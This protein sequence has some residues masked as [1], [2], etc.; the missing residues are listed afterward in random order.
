[1]KKDSEKIEEKTNIDE[2][3]ITKLPGIVKDELKKVQTKSS[4][5]EKTTEEYQPYLYLYSAMNKPSVEGLV[6]SFCSEDEIADLP[7]TITSWQ[8]ARSDLQRI[9]N[10]EAGIA[11]N[12]QTYD[13]G[14]NQKL[15]DLQNDALFRNT[16]SNNPIEF[17]MVDID[18]LIATQRHVYLDYV[19]EIE[20]TI[21][22]NPSTDDLIDICLPI[23][24]TPPEPKV[25]NIG[26]GSWLFSSPS[27]D[28]RYLGGYLKERLTEDD[29]RYTHV[30]GFPIKAI[31][32]FVGYG[33]SP[34]NV[35]HVNNRLVLNN[36][37]HRVFAL[38]RKGITRIPVVIQQVAN[39][40]FEFPKEILTL[41]REYLINDPRP[42]LVK[43]FFT[44]GLTRE[45]KKKKMI[46]TV[47]VTAQGGAITFEV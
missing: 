29:L 36:G 45:F 37:F 1:M 13:I 12:A 40:E 5:K 23:R 17:K 42:I 34:I 33:G 30:S 18:T 19:N 26:P 24:P 47:Q 25:T 9:V 28:C 39:P 22:A 15:D 41:S 35:Y 20:N 16:F 31:T 6:R 4:N 38:R 44:N 14:Q 3:S 46:T 27:P 10:Q 32:L 43:D 8:Q 2:L 11:N 21:T 7:N